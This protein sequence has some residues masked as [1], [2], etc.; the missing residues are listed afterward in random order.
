MNKTRAFGLFLFILVAGLLLASAGCTTDNEEDFFTVKNPCDTT[1]VSYSTHI[2]PVMA[3]SCN[4]C[5]APGFPSGGVITSTHQ[6]LSVVAG[7]GKLKGA[8]FHQMGFTAMPP[9]QNM[10]DSC[11]LN[12]I[13]AWINQG[14]QNN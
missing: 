7:N 5:H 14:Y 8:V 11:S 12:R 2:A 9:G 13:A 1:L 4:S 10:L 6:G 3:N